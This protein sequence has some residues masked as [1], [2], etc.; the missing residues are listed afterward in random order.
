M[1]FL[2]PNQQCPSSNGLTTGNNI[3]AITI[4]GCGYYVKLMLVVGQMDRSRLKEYL[5]G[6]LF[7]VEIHDRDRIIHKFEE[8]SS[9]FG[10]ERDDDLLS[11]P[12]TGLHVVRCELSVDSFVPCNHLGISCT[13]L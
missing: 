13:H 9:L 12:D 4:S 2:S 5:Y 6:L 3:Y 10:E 11:V 7:E 8:G 1:S